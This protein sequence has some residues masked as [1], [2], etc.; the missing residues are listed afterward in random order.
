MNDLESAIWRVRAGSEVDADFKTLEA[1]LNP[2]ERVDDRDKEIVVL[3]LKHAPRP[4][5]RK[6]QTYLSVT[7]DPLFVGEVISG[8]S[9]RGMREGTFV[10]FVREVASGTSWDSRSEARQLALTALPR[11]AARDDI[12]EILRRSITDQDEIISD[13]AAIAA[14][15]AFGLHDP[16]VYWG[17]GSG[18]V[19]K[20][21]NAS[22]REWLSLED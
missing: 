14:Q 16:D 11:I 10:Q 22:V 15:Y 6:M 3:L 21:M 19:Y 5:L 20:K 2:P 9:R 7:E 4:D 13:S 17:R 18:D 12:R 8:L 1:G